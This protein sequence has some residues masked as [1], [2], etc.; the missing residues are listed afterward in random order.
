MTEQR[1]TA[2]LR[3]SLLEIQRL[4]AALAAA[5]ARASE[6]IAVIGIACRTPGG[7]EDPDGFWALLDAGRDVI[8]PPPDRW[9]PLRDSLARRGVGALTD[10]EGFDAEHFGITPKEAAVMDPQQRIALELAWEALERAGIDPT[11]LQR[12]A[13]GVY[14]GATSSDYLGS[15]DVRESGDGQTLTGISPS[16]IAGRVA[17][18]LGLQGPAMTLDTACSSSLVAVHLACTALRERECERALAGGVHVMGSAAAIAA[19]ERMQVSAPDGRCKPFAAAAD[20]AGWS[21]GAGLL[22]LERQSDALRNGHRVLALI[23]GSAVNH[24]GRS[25][26]LTAPNGISQ[27]RLLEQA[28]RAAGLTPADIDAIEAHGTG[29]PLGDPIEAAALAAVFGP[30][31]AIDRPLWLGSC[32]SNIGHTQCAAGILGLIKLILALAHERLPPTLHAARPSPAIDWRGGKLALVQRGQVWPRSDARVR[33]AGVSSFGI[34]GTNA[35]VIVEEPARD[36]PIESLPAPIPLLLSAR[37]PAAIAAQAARWAE[38]IAAH[39]NTPRADIVRTAALRRAQLDVRAAVHGDDHHELARALRELADGYVEPRRARARRDVVF[40]FPGQG[41]QWPGMAH[42]LLR[43]SEV[44]A[45]TIATCDAAFAAIT[46]WSVRAALDEHTLHDAAEIAQPLQFAMAVGLA[47][48]WRSFGVE[49]AAVIGHSLGEVAAAVTAGA[50]TIE[51]GARVVMARARLVGRVSGRGGLLF[52]ALAPAELEQRLADAAPELELAVVNGESSC[53]V[54]GGRAALDRFAAALEAEGVFVRRV[55]ADYA[56]HS[57]H[58]DELLE[59]IAEALV[60]LAPCSCPVEFLSTVTGTALDGATLD[61][62]YWAR[63][64]RAPVRFDRALARALERGGDVLIEISSHPL[65]VSVIEDTCRERGRVVVPSLLRGRGSLAQLL[66]S[67]G[68]LH[69]DGQMIT[70]PRIL[71][72]TLGANVPLPTQAFIRR[73]HWRARAIPSTSAQSPVTATREH[74]PIAAMQGQLTNFAALARRQLE[75]LTYHTLDS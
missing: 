62:A 58:M 8:G 38:W 75:A 66:R 40:V 10:V 53:A 13:T 70:W 29:T 7:V 51:Q 17:Y 37:S 5:D 30:S 45:D 54:A 9:G 42:A 59:P 43:E 34:S 18:L 65:L 64:L 21:E 28:L 52:V 24:D 11:S 4:R 46:P 2:L 49:P 12:S 48:L 14:L 69:V 31:R 68:E 44:F 15:D 61:G 36:R 16:V 72:S 3:E 6:P 73:R 47:A 25:Q 56:S 50:L 60:G 19:F 67:A 23:R 41:A 35:H 71:G 39:P 55:H 57:R 26:G 27:Q 33:R 22:V 74:E 32:K 63:N 20:G 1:A